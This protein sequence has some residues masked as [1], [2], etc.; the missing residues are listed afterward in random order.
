MSSFHPA[1][2]GLKSL[3]VRDFRNI[4]FAQIEFSPH[5]N[6]L[7]GPNG[8]GKTNYLE[9]ISVACSLRPMQGLN[10]CDLVRFQTSQA[11]ILAEFSGHQR[12]E[13]EILP[14]GKKARLNERPLKA[15]QELARAISLV[16]FIPAELSMVSGTNALRRRALDQASASLFFEYANGL[17]SYEKLLS[18]RNR[19]LKDWPIDKTLLKTF[20]DLLIKEAAQIIFFRLQTLD[21]MESIFAQLIKDI[22]GQNHT[23][24]L[25]YVR[26]DQ[27]ESKLS[28]HDI[29]A[30]LSDEH[31]QVFSHELKRRMTLFGPHLDDLAFNLDGINAKRT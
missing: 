13:I 26:K 10:N 21:K 19:L 11:K 18:H 22:L 24:T 8:H 31:T 1:H 25:G 23:G 27:V 28:L 14:L 2:H 17:K 29:L 9:A 15:T 3:V 16:S 6:L 7:V 5:H 4:A 12:L 20:T 30:K